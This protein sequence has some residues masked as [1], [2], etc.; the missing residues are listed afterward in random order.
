MGKKGCQGLSEESV[1]KGPS[2]QQRAAGDAVLTGTAKM[3]MK[4]FSVGQGDLEGHRHY[5]L[6][7]LCLSHPAKCLQACSHSRPRGGHISPLNG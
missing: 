1:P 7:A 4:L 6:S 2:E 3:K 5:V